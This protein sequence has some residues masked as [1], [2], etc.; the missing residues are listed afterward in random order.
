VGGFFLS[1]PTAVIVVFSTVIIVTIMITMPING[2]GITI[3]VNAASGKPV[4]ALPRH[5]GLA[6]D[7]AGTMAAFLVEIWVARKP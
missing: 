4:C 3:A 7:L 5:T 2:G 6:V 1:S